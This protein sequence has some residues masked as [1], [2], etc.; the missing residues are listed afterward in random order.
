MKGC[1]LSPWYYHSWKKW[2]KCSKCCQQMYP[3]WA[4]LKGCHEKTL[5]KEIKQQLLWM[6][7]K[8]H[9]WW[10][11]VP[12]VLSNMDECKKSIPVAERTNQKFFFWARFFLDNSKITIRHVW[13]KVNKVRVIFANERESA[14]KVNLNFSLM[15]RIKKNVTRYQLDS[16]AYRRKTVGINMIILCT[17]LL[18][19]KHENVS[20]KQVWVWLP[21]WMTVWS[22]L[23]AFTYSTNNTKIVR[24]W[25]GST[26]NVT[27]KNKNDQ[28]WIRK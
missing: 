3:S 14:C 7:L 27:Q 8:L 11:P 28:N 25:L 9:A 6:I 2:R 26:L 21:M 24:R 20:T 4:N 1:P 23:E 15:I 18:Q 13:S 17:V 22:I 10:I 19:D 5:T 16:S 12:N